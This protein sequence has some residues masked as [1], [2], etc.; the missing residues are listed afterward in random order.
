MELEDIL[1]NQCADV[2]GMAKFEPALLHLLRNHRAGE[3]VPVAELY[4]LAGVAEEI[5]PELAATWLP[6]PTN[7]PGYVVIFFCDDE[8]MWSLTAYHNADR[9]LQPVTTLAEGPNPVG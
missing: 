6:S 2:V 7:Q 5:K 3:W 4:R 9:L 8:L 1:S